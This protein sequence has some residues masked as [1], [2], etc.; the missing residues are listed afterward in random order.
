MSRAATGTARAADSGEAV[1]RGLEG[2][3]QKSQLPLTMLLFLCPLIVLYEVGT[4]Q[5][6]CDTAR[7][8]ETR[9]LA[10]NLMRDFLRLFGATGKYLPCLAV[11]GVLFTRHMLR[12]DKWELHPGVAAGIALESALLA[13][14]VLALS[15]LLGYYLPLYAQDNGRMLGL[16]LSLGAGIYEELVFRMMTFALLSFIL[17]D[18]LRLG[19][20]SAAILTVFAS[21][22]F[23]AA[24]HYWSPQS[25]AF[26]WRDFIFRSGSGIYFGALYL[27][28]G[29]AVTAGSHTFYDLYYFLL[30]PA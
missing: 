8:T 27:V 26:C 1:V 7:H 17:M 22:A 25:D 23:F 15:T 29:F 13:V 6:A 21:A 11:V 5:F 18:L 10:F 12:R 9:V 14:P 28:R 4:R 3:F 16:V 20:T 30:C 2:Y 24:Y 19:H